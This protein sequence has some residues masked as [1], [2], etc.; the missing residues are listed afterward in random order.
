MVTPAAVGAAASTTEKLRARPRKRLHEDET[1]A[2][3]REKRGVE[4]AQA[5]SLLSSGS[6]ADVAAA[7]GA[8]AA[9]ATAAST[10]DTAP[11]EPEPRVKKPSLKKKGQAEDVIDGRKYKRRRDL[12]L[13]HI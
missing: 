11:R 2:G 13:I 9:D 8:P 10:V 12:S 5:N 6:G 3:D 1:V 4:G 7:D